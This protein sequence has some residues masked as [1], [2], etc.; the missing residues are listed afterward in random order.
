MKAI[1]IWMT[2]TTLRL[3]AAGCLSLDRRI[4]PRAN[5]KSHPSHPSYCLSG[6]DDTTPLPKTKAWFHP[7]QTGK[8]VIKG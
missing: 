3:I 5:H 6:R 2:S 4:L 7:R 8:N 1:L